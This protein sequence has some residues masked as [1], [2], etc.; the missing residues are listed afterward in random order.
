M[1]YFKFEKDF[2]C[3]GKGNNFK[4]KWFS[5]LSGKKNVVCDVNRKN[6]T[7]KVISE[8]QREFQ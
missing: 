3:L 5:F 8:I 4:I 2:S 7:E 6:G 1:F